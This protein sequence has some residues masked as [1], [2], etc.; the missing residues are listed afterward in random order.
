MANALRQLAFAVKLFGFAHLFHVAIKLL[1]DVFHHRKA[2]NGVFL[3]GL[4][5]LSGAQFH[6]VEI[7]NCFSQL[8]GEVYKGGLELSESQTSGM[9]IFFVHRL[10]DI[11][12]GY[13]QHHAPISI[14]GF[15]PI[16]LA[17]FGLDEGQHTAVD[18]GCGLLFQFLSQVRS[19]GFDVSL[20]QFHIFKD[21][22]VDALQHVTGGVRFVHRHLIGV[23]NQSV[24]QWFHALNGAL[25][26]EMRHQLEQILFFHDDNMIV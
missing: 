2:L 9:R 23:V 24:S 7:G 10:I 3:H 25:H 13:K 14:V 19:N 17:R 22:I 11:G 15:A 4:F 1:N 12:I 20:Q 16:S 21:G 6:V 26:V 18:V 8:R 5:Q